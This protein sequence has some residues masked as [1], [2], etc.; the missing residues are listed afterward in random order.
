VA[1]AARARVRVR[2]T[3]DC[4]LNQRNRG[5]GGGKPYIA[6]YG[7]QNIERA[8]KEVFSAKHSSD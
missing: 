5:G 2:L 6:H 7:L 1:T 4:M 3:R 8:V